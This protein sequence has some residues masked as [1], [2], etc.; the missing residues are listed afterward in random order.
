MITID[1]TIDI[2][3]RLPV[4]QQEMLID[5]LYRQ[6]LER[7]RKEIAEDAMKSIADFHSGKIQSNPVQEIISELRMTT[8]GICTS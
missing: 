1:Y 2:V 5:I 6:N 3:R 7:R 8:D 4:E